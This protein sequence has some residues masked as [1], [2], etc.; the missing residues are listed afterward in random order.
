MVAHHIQHHP[1]L[2]Q[3]DIHANVGMLT[4]ADQGYRLACHI[5][6]AMQEIA[7]LFEFKIAVKQFLYQVNPVQ[8]HYIAPFCG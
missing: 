8:S 6:G 1:C 2:P 5:G 7:L 3:G 4:G